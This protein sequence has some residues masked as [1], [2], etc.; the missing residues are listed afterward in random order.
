MTAYL[1]VTLTEFDGILTK[2]INQGH[3]AIIGANHLEIATLD[4]VQGLTALR[5]T[6]ARQQTEHETKKQLQTKARVH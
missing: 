2:L 4:K 6:E 1:Q 3:G 5:H